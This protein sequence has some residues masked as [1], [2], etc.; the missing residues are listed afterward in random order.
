MQRANFLSD[1]IKLER[2]ENLQTITKLEA[3]KLVLFT[4]TS[5]LESCQTQIVDL[6]RKCAEMQDE[7]SSL[8]KSQSISNTPT[9]MD[10]THS[11]SSK[12]DWSTSNSDWSKSSW[13]NNQSAPSSWQH[14][15]F[16]QS[17]SSDGTSTHTYQ[18]NWSNNYQPS[19]NDQQQQAPMVPWQSQQQPRVVPREPQFPPPQALRD[20][21]QPFPN[22][23]SSVLIYLSQDI[24]EQLN[25]MGV[26]VMQQHL[27]TLGMR[28]PPVLGFVANP[29][30]VL[31]LL[32]GMVVVSIRA[33]TQSNPHP[34]SQKPSQHIPSPSKSSII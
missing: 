12:S 14:A 19:W 30:K 1:S 28:S 8:K 6:K 32:F 5:M 21:S 10:T 31:F 23:S 16:T 29:K 33:P 4:T 11:S 9:P 26:E 25:T 17:S 20:A 7:M 24:L 2:V 27:H 13:S 18:Q 22:R 15:S 34:G 3:V